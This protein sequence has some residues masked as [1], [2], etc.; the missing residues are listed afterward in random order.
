MNK[1]KL[2]TGIVF[3]VLLSLTSVHAEVSPETVVNIF[4]RLEALENKSREL[5][6]ENEVLKHQL[7]QLKKAQKQGFLSIDERM[8]ALANTEKSAQPETPK[9]P[10]AKDNKVTITDDAKAKEVTGE[11]KEPAVKITSSTT[12]AET[13]KATAKPA[14][15]KKIRAPNS[16]ERE[17]Y[18]A[19]FTLMKKSG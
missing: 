15:K 2:Q 1:I 11:K 6:G 16:Y 7:S 17:T 18:Q 14:P 10:E 13:S 9:Q 4:Q 19:A 5:T 3:G 12:T 8:D